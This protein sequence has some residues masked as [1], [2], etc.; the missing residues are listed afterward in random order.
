M[1]KL[2]VLLLLACFHTSIASVVFSLPFF[3]SLLSSP[4]LSLSVFFSVSVFF[5]SCSS[6]L[7]AAFCALFPSP[8]PIHPYLT[9]WH[10]RQYCHLQFKF[11]SINMLQNIPS[12]T[13]LPSTRVVLVVWTLTRGSTKSFC[14]KTANRCCTRFLNLRFYVDRE[15]HG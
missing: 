13:S 6:G 5:L 9:A 3:L 4:F 8:P 7:T 12:L 11:P 15:T 10:L 2:L 1:L 14:P